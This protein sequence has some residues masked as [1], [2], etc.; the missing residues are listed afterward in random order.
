MLSV[1][2]IILLILIFYLFFKYI[3]HNHSDTFSIENNELIPSIVDGNQ[4]YV[5]NKHNN[6]IDAAD[7]FSVVNNRVTLFID[8]LYE[9]HKNSINPR[10]KKIST[11]LKTR[12]NS[13]SL[14][15]SSPLNEDKDTSFTINKGDIM[16][17]CIRSKIDKTNKIHKFN[18]IFFVVLHEIAH[19][20]LDAF[21]HPTE[22]WVNFKFIL[23]EAEDLGI[24]TSPD[25]FNNSIEY[26]GIY[27]NY[28]PRYDYKIEII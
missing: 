12:F 23:M 4:Y 9:K 26:C 13:S 15:E 8:A 17:I 22:F 1:I 28:N 20:S 18:V 25:F 14:R 19:L 27:I 21:D 5:H 6:K 11:L 10:R 2:I 16:A 24:Y 3:L 7:M